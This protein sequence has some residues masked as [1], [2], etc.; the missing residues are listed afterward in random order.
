MVRKRGDSGQYVESIT[1]DAVLGVFERVEGPVITSADVAER[2]DCSADAARR[3]LDELHESGRVDRRKTAG[4]L[5]YWLVD[6]DSV[7]IDPDDPLFTDP[8]TFESGESDVSRTV[9]EQLY[10]PVD[11]ERDDAE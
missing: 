11:A 6:T 10:G 1:H 3:K 7:T 8:P 4:R 5:V 9:D 2:L